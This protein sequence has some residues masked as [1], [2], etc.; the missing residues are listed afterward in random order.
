VETYSILARGADRIA[1]A[2]GLYSSMVAVSGGVSRSFGGYGANYRSRL[3]RIYN[4][5]GV[6]QE[7]VGQTDIR[8]RYG[9]PAVHF[10]LVN[11]GRLSKQKNQR[12]LLEMLRD[13][14]D[15]TLLIVGDGELAGEMRRSAAS[16]GV[17]TRVRF[18]GELPME[19]VADIL[20]QADL[21]LLPSLYESFCLAAVEAMQH[22]LPVVATDMACLREVLGDRQLFFP[23][24]D[25][26]RLLAIVARLLVSPE[27]RK[28]MAEA[29]RARARLFSVERMVTEYECLI[30]EAGLYGRPRTSA[31]DNFRRVDALGGIPGIHD[32]L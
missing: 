25:T 32:Q 13:L 17:A 5:I 6:Q 30:Q 3:H 18:T 20:Q 21:F 23:L 14:D 15:A 27:E 16:F 10:V 24:N 11:V 1:F 19:E 9:I 26:K 8:V 31:A 12:L 22:G 29:G 28:T 7:H 2:L 4:G